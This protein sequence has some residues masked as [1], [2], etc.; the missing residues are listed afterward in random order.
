VF[1]TTASRDRAL[2][3]TFTIL[4]TFIDEG[5]ETTD[6]LTAFARNTNPLITQLRPAARELSPT[7]ADLRGL[8]PDLKGLFRDLGPLIDASAKGIPATEQILRDTRPLL[9][10]LD[11]FLRDLNPVLNYLGLYKK[12]IA[13]FFSL[14]VA[15]TQAVDRP[16]GS[17]GPVHYLRTANPI[18]PENLAAYPR[19]IAT[20]RPNPYPTPGSAVGKPPKV[21]GTY[22]CGT[23]AIPP[24]APPGTLPPDPIALP[25][26][27]ALPIDPA[28]TVDQLDD[29]LRNL[30][31]TYAYAGG[32]PVAPPCVEQAPL[33]N[34]IGQSGKYP[35]VQEDP[36]K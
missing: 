7:L 26:I 36:A 35:H 2:Q 23:A 17:N 24:L 11:P 30:I 4:P 27:P 14:D 1:A 15:A 8:A 25:G 34:L 20:N 9:R 21:F 33:G 5:R 13:S 10:Q 16:P 32:N 22:A 12:E 29:N 3:E 6:R 28:T 31:N 19:R 18:N